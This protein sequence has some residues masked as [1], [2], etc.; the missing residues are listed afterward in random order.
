MKTLELYKV[1]FSTKDFDAY[2]QWDKLFEAHLRNSRTADAPFL[3]PMPGPKLYDRFAA[4]HGAFGADMVAR[5][6]ALAVESIIGPRDVWE[7]YEV[8]VLTVEYVGSV[9]VEEPDLVDDGLS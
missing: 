9:T 8:I 5:A 7:K 1:R 4:V 2:K 6:G 3:T